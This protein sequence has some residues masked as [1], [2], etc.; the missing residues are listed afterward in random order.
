[1]RNEKLTRL[2]SVVLAET[3]RESLLALQ[4]GIGRAVGNV[5]QPR[6]PTEESTLRD[7]LSR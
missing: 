3:E 2:D 6:N 1:M 7:S 5:R 4:N